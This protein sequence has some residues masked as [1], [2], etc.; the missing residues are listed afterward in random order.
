[1]K[2]TNLHINHRIIRF[3]YIFFVVFCSTTLAIADNNVPPL[4]ARP[5]DK[6]ETQKPV[7]AEV[8][9][10]KMKDTTSSNNEGSGTQ[11][12]DSGMLQGNSAISFIVKNLG[13][14][15]YDVVYNDKK[16]V[17]IDSP[18][19]LYFPVKEGLDFYVLPQ[20]ATSPDVFTLNTRVQI[21]D[22]DSKVN[23]IKAIAKARMNEPLVYKGIQTNGDSYIIVLTLSSEGDDQQQ[24]GQQDKKDEQE[25]KDNE[26]DKQNLEEQEQEQQPEQKENEEENKEGEN[27]QTKI[28]LESLD[29]MDQKEQKEMLNDR[30]RIMLPDKWW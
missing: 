15:D 12:N 20:G 7:N 28:L 30:E 1:M 14:K 5:G 19:E 13:I 2:Q 6:E 25:Q 22:G 9:A 8:V 29:E 24:G 17:S 10:V 16:T 21:A 27:Q 3:A 11:S 23:A 26:Q 4:L 18:V